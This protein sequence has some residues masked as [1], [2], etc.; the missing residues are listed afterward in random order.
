MKVIIRCS[1]C[2]KD[3]REGEWPDN[4]NYKEPVVSHGYCDECYKI[5]MK[6][7][8]ADFIVIEKRVSKE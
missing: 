1:K 5:V 6:D 4:P 3:I 8:E 2:G 7:A